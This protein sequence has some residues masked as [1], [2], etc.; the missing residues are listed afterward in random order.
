M[1]VFNSRHIDIHSCDAEFISCGLMQLK[2]NIMTFSVT[3]SLTQ[4]NEAQNNDRFPWYDISEG[5]SKVKHEMNGREMIPLAANVVKEVVVLK[6]CCRGYDA[7]IPYTSIHQSI[8]VITPYSMCP[9]SWPSQITEVSFCYN[10]LTM[11]TRPTALFIQN[12]P[13][14]PH[15]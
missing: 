8:R 10:L 13:V 1:E 4:F 15:Y 7:L 12:V 2:M 9:W 14:I 11:V 6:T 5:R 3:H